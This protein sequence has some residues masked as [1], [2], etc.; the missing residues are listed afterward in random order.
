MWCSLLSTVKKYQLSL[1]FTGIIIGK[2]GSSILHALYI[3]LFVPV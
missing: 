1:I 3:I 2:G